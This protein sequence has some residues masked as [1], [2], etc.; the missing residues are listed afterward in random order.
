MQEIFPSLFLIRPAQGLAPTPF[1]YL[2]KRPA[3]N[4]LFATKADLAG[5]EEAILAKGKVSHVLLGDRHHALPAT[6][7][8][9]RRLGVGLS[10]SQIEALALKR[11][12]VTVTLPLPLQ[13]QQLAPDLEIIPTPGHTPGAFAYRWRH[14]GRHFLFIGDT[15]VPVNGEWKFWVTSAK[16]A[17]LRQSLRDLA[18]I[19]FDVILSN[20]FA[21]APLAW[22]E[23]TAQDRQ[24]IFAALD[25]QLAA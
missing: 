18:K 24:K 20:S 6:E 14:Q 7:A 22:I 5:Q 10:C 15:L 23:V 16:R 1:T 17:L 9:A 11:Q 12:G 2:L 4:V 25:R 3:G 19:P 8:M 13:A 21:A